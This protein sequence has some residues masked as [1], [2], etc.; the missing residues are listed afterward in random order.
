[1]NY[2]RCNILGENRKRQKFAEEKKS[3]DIGFP[4]HRMLK[5]EETKLKAEHRRQIKSNPEIEKQSRKLQC[6]LNQSQRNYSLT[7]P[8]IYISELVNNS[9]RRFG[10]SE[11][12]LA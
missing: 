2:N 9:E 10:S 7:I 4:A 1:M 6:K 11:A 3:V 12:V 8:N 5:S